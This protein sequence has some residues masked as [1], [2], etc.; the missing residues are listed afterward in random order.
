[1]ISRAPGI[2]YG[3]LAIGLAACGL[4]GIGEDEDVGGGKPG[5]SSGDASTP[6]VPATSSGSPNATSSSGSSSG[7]ITQDSGPDAEPRVCLHDLSN[8]DCPGNA[9]FACQGTASKDGDRF[10][11]TQG[12]VQAGALWMRVDPTTMHDFTA[13][14]DVQI[15]PSAGTPDVG[16][17]FAFVF[18]D[19]PSE[20]PRIGPARNE[21][22]L[23]ASNL[24]VGSGT[25]VFWRSFRVGDANK[26]GFLAGYTAV[27][28][29]DSTHVDQWADAGG[30]TES[31]EA[32]LG[33]VVRIHVEHHASDGAKATATFGV[34][35][36]GAPFQVLDPNTRT[37]DLPAA[38][39]YVGV[40]ANTGHPNFATNSTQLVS[41]MNVHCTFP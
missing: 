15:D 25:A 5:S 24:D 40:T 29:D 12:E 6:G 23:G 31:F 13:E 28:A 19:A 30:T 36:N 20:L 22:T 32:S 1:M 11:L 7:T 38:V 37:F 14:F 9:D 18:V 8:A 41:A 26:G 27:P 2:A 35:R 4:A 33:A 3:F 21:P 10:R 16:N 39:H 17:G 34:S